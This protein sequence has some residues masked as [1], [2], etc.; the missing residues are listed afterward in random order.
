MVAKVFISYRRDDSAGH[1]G[2][3]HDKLAAEFGRDLLFMD[4]DAIP[5]GSDF[6]K[7]LKEEVTKCDALL[8][9]IGP[10]WLQVQDDRGRRRLDDPN[11]FVRVEIAAA[12]QRDISVVAILLEGT[13][14]PK[15]EVLPDN[16]KELAHRNGLGVRHASFHADI[17]RLIGFLKTRLGLAPSQVASPPEP[18]QLTPSAT[19]YLDRGIAHYNNGE[20][21]RAVA[22]ITRSIEI[23]PDYFAAYFHRG[24]ALYQNGECGRAVEDITRAIEMQPRSSSDYVA[25]VSNF[26]SVRGLA[27]RKKG[28]YA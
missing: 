23:K 10:N 26:Y 6:V 20:Y 17:D 18:I 21:V 12:L 25:N 19:E 8:A 15:V 24:F 11:D 2:R 22:D 7:V 16:L 27:Y 28:E 1:A 3:I 9:I 4:V 13:E 5:L 14:V